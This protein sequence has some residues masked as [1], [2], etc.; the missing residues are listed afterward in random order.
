M[1]EIGPFQPKS[2]SP[3]NLLIPMEILFVTGLQS[4]QQKLKVCT[5]S[6]SIRCEKYP[7]NE[8]ESTQRT[9]VFTGRDCTV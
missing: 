5:N 4:T 3:N 9:V 8:C 2:Q 1:E 6:S 7:M